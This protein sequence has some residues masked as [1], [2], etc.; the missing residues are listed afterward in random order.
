MEDITKTRKDDTVKTI[1]A[2]VG[3]SRVNTKSQRKT[4]ELPKSQ[5]L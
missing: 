2:E 5:N 3:Y 1:T 4:V